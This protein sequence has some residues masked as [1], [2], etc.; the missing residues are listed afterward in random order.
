V[1]QGKTSFEPYHVHGSR[2]GSGHPFLTGGKGTGYKNQNRRHHK[3]EEDGGL[4]RTLTLLFPSLCN[5]RGV[6]GTNDM[7]LT[8]KR[9]KGTWGETSRS[10]WRSVHGR[11]RDILVKKF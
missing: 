5:E 7:S 3:R 1:G 10:V 9:G 8:W 2:E 4:G 6:A 11:K